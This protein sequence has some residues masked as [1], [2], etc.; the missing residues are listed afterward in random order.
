MRKQFQ[1]FSVTVLFLLQSLAI[2]AA[3]SYQVPDSG[4]EDWSDSFNGNPAPGATWNAANLHKVAVGIHVYGQVCHRVGGADAHSG[5]YAAK[6]V[7]TEVGAA[8][9]T[10]VSP[11]WI[12]LGTPWA[13]IDGIKTGTATAGTDGGI[14]FTH[15]PDTMAVWVK[16]VSEGTENINLVYY[17]WKGTAKGNR[18]KNKDGGCEPTDEHTDEE[19]DIR[20]Q[21][22]PNIC[23]S[24]GNALQIG[25]GALRTNAQYKN[26]TQIKVPI[27]YYNDYTPEKMNIILSA[28]NYP[29]GRRN[30][31][32]YNGNYMIVD[33]LSLIYSSKIHEIRLNNE[34]LNK[35]KQDVYVYSVS[36]GDKATFR[37]IPNITCKR[38]GRTLSG[39]EITINYAEQ[40]GDTTTITV[41]A[42]D[43]SSTSTYKVVFKQTESINSNA[44]A[45][46]VNGKSIPSF[47]GYVT[48]YNV[49]LP[50][51]T[52]DAPEI[53]VTKSEQSQDVEVVSCS[54]FPCVAK[55]IVRAENRSYE[56]VYNINLS[57][58]QLSDNTLQDIKI[59]GNSIPGFKPETNTYLVELPLGTTA[60]PTIEAVSKYKEGDQKITITNAGLNG[61]STIVVTPPVGTSRTYRI[62]YV[63]TESSYSYLK[64]IQVG[65]VSLA[66]FNP[67]TTQYE[68]Q[69]P[70]GTTKLPA[71]TWTLGDPYQTV[72][73]SEDGV[74]GTARITVKA[75][76]GNITIYR[77]A[78]SVEKSTV[79]TLNNIF[80]N[81]IP[82][83]GFA[84]DTYEYVYNVTGAVSTRPV[85]T[86]ETADAYQVVTKNP[87]SEST[88][89]LEGVTKLTVRAQNGNSA[90]YSITFTQKLSDN[91]N[92][93]DLQVAGY[94]LTP[95]FNSDITEYTCKLNRGTSTVPAITFVKGDDT[96][97][98]RVDE[99]GVNGVTK[100]TVKAQTGATK[101]Y[102]ITFSVE[103]SSD[104]TLKDILVGGVSVDG[105]NPATLEYN[106]TLPAGTTVLPTVEAVKND[107]AQRIAMIKGGVN[108]TTE[109][110]VVAEDGTEQTYLLHFSVEKSLNAN[111]QNIYVGGEPLPNFDPDVMMYRYVLA[112]N[113]SSCPIVKAEGYPGQTITTTMPKL[114]GTARIEVQPEI[115]SANV[116][117]IE[118]VREMSDNNRLKNMMV[119]GKDFGFTPE[120]NDYTITMPEGTTQVPTV[121]YSKGED[122][123]TVQIISGGLYG[124]TQVVVVAEDGSKNIYSISFTV[125]QSANVQLKGIYV[126]GTL[127]SD[128]DPNKLTYSYKL[129]NGTTVLPEVT[130]KSQ[131]G[132]HVSLLLPRLEGDA[133]FE[134]TSE[135]GAEKATYVVTFET[136]KLSDATL[137]GIFLDGNTLAGFDAQIFDYTLDI[138]KGAKLPVITYKK[139]DATQQVVVNNQGLNGC[140]LTVK[141]QSGVESTYTIQFNELVSSSAL[142]SDIQFY[143]SA[144]QT[145]TSIDN[146][147][148]NTFEYNIQL[149]WGTKVLPIINPVPSTY[150]QEIQMTEGGVNGV[151]TILVKSADETVSETYKLNF[152][153]E[154]SS[155]ATLD[156]ILV[157][158]NDVPGF[159]PMTFEY[160]VSLPYGTEMVPAIDFEHAKKNG[161]PIVGQKVEI[162][163][164]GLINGVR[165]NVTSEDETDKRT[166]ILRFKV[167]PS[168]KPNVLKS[169][170]AG[171][172]SVPL[173][174]GVFDYNITLPEGVTELPQLTAEKTYSEQEVRVAKVANSY[175]VTVISN[176]DNVDDVVYTITCNYTKPSMVITGV[177]LKNGAKL[178]PAFSPE[179][180]QYMAQASSK[181]DISFLYDDSRY[182]MKFPAAQNTDK[183]ITAVISKIGDASESKTYTFYLYQGEWN[184]NYPN[185][186]L[187]GAQTTG[188][189]EKEFSLIAPVKSIKFKSKESGWTCSVGDLVLYEYVN[190]WNEI[191]R[192]VDINCKEW[193][194]FESGVNPQAQ[195]LKFL[196]TKG[197]TGYAWA[198]NIVVEYAQP[199]IHSLKVNNKAATKNGNNFTVTI[200][201]DAYGIP[202]LDIISDVKNNTYG[203]HWQ[204]VLE[205]ESYDIKWG[206]EVD[207]E[208]KA[209]IVYYNNQ[210]NSFTYTL[211]V[212]R[213][214]STTNT[215]KELVV[216][217]AKNQ[218]AKLTPAFDPE[219]LEYSINIPYTQRELPNISVA[220]TSAYA[221]VS[222]SHINNLSNP[223][224]VS[225]INVTVTSQSGTNR[226]YTVRVLPSPTDESQLIDLSVEGYDID[227]SSGKDHFYVTLPAGTD[228]LP[229]I[230]YTKATDGQKVTINKGKTTTIHVKSEHLTET[231]YYIHF[232]NEEVNTHAQLDLLAVLNVDNMAPQFESGV[233]EYNAIRTDKHPVVI[234]NKVGNEDGLTVT[235]KKDLVK[236]DLN[237]S[238]PRSGVYEEASYVVN[239][240]E[241]VTDNASLETIKINGVGLANFDAQTTDY[242]IPTES[243]DGI[244]IEPVLSEVGQT[245][246]MTFDGTTKTYTIVLTASDKQ[247]VKTYTVKFVQPIS[248]NANL[249]AIWIDNQMISG[250]DANVTEYSYTVRYTDSETPQP[251]WQ[252]PVMPDIKAVGA[253]MG[254]TISIETNG[255]NGKSY[256]NV[257]AENGAEKTY[258]IAFEA[259]KSDYV[260][261]K[262]IFKDSEAITEFYPTLNV[263]E[264]EVP[265]TVQR[266]VIS[267]EPGDAFQVINEVEEADKHIIVVTAQSGDTFTYTINFNKTYAKNALLNGIT[268]DGE[269]L[270]G[271]TSDDYEY[272][273]E[274]PVG[275]TVLPII[276]VIN[277]ADGQTTQVVTN[278]VHG[279]A[280]I[281]VTADDNTTTQTYTIHFTVDK[282]QVNTLLDI[283]LD[284]VSLEG[285]EPNIYEYTHNMPVGSR[286]WPLVSWTAGDAYQT[287]EMSETEIDTWNKVVTLLVK[288]EDET[289]E[290]KTYTVNIIVEKS[291]V[292]TLKDIQL[293]NV[294]LEG[295][296]AET[297][298]YLIELPVGTKQYPLVTYT[299]GDEFQVVNQEVEDNKV[300]I[301]VTAE[302]GA[303]RTY[304]LEFV[305]LH[306]SNAT[307]NSISV[308][309]EILPDFSPEKLAYNYVLPYGTTEMPIVTYE[310]GDKWQNI[311][312]VDGGINGD[313]VINV[314]AEDDVTTLS[315][316]I[317][318]SVALSNNA[319]LSDILVDEQSMPNFDSEVF[320]Y[321]YNLPYNVTEIPTVTAVTIEGQ[322]VNI[323]N[324]TSIDEVTT[325][326]VTAE[327]G[328]TKNVYTIAWENEKSSNALLEMIYLNGVEL[329]GYD[330]EVSDYD[331]TL[332]YGTTQMPEITWLAGDAD[333]TVTLQ[334]NEQTA[335]L[336]VEAQ[337]GTP[338]EYVLTFTVEKSSENR[339][340]DLA[341][342]GVTIEGFD[343]E[344]VEYRIVY[345]A[346]TSKEEVVTVSQV[347]YQLFNDSETVTLLNNDMVLMIQVMA[348]NGD[349]RTYVIVQEIALSNNTL[350]DDILID[351]ES[352]ENFDPNTFEYTY[353]LPFGSAIVPD[354][355]RYVSSDTTQNVSVSVNPLPMPSEIFV[356]AEDGSKAVYRIHF[357]VDDFDPATV[358]TAD[359]VC[360]TSMPNGK[361]KF[362]TNCNNVTIYLSTIDGKV[363]LVAPLPLVD[364]NVPNIC[365]EQAQGFIFEERV[366]NIVAYYFIHNKQYIIQSGK[367]R[368]SHQ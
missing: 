294:S 223:E 129:N 274:L 367:L 213:P 50:Y 263:Y 345:P 100:I 27:T 91:V 284:G 202:T 203:A 250:F 36:L 73:V 166:Y 338:G 125:Q 241:K 142:L 155:V 272:D 150:G 212:K 173:K 227:F 238:L 23:G 314:K 182:E 242:E 353:Y 268:L 224:A 168:G 84:P 31:G 139:Q 279:D 55:V 354:D 114:V 211:T 74:D 46:S 1:V 298:E 75:Q 72:S 358:P 89:S 128:F 159:D 78:F 88:V 7:D 149:P 299:K 350:L 247:T 178:Y 273:V 132:Q 356:T 65:G 130:Y 183:K 254:Q 226:M 30:D 315:Y 309:Y 194:E 160:T 261:L 15:R 126:G 92:L 90:V 39:D 349:M 196:I 111:L 40:L 365:D 186:E 360:V 207:G 115:G 282:S 156:N 293:D 9:I 80:V 120:Q 85:V 300:Y 256:I 366:D 340:K 66:D 12:T 361:W 103:T 62:S 177:E 341:I 18:Y 164:A 326:T 81:G 197:V 190:G 127:L 318:F 148:E 118:F 222:F 102:S 135:D 257:K 136:E 137:K 336:L 110:K 248:D 346:G 22:D 161:N 59:N 63:I 42:E 205:G 143:N 69:L 101:V 48:D 323:V 193:V 287:V 5:N 179:V 295:Y 233:Y 252:E 329:E 312:V 343:P 171:Q 184:K 43:G 58:G 93:T 208:R 131:E 187:W 228:V 25:E 17:S 6:L 144:T 119:N 219:R 347:T 51:G 334:W 104:A 342:N 145:F 152:S 121:T 169:M 285:F 3:S 199:G 236:L 215:L 291:D 188:S 99:N 45:I 339:L 271:F 265:V 237:C 185:I 13:Y 234:Y 322:S 327:D 288:P 70:L 368:V 245:M 297:T 330:P 21:T 359:N 56:T 319:L 289:I 16:R 249:S 2:I 276:G 201:Q 60:D 123:Q 122:K 310:A 116:Y 305:I 337:D 34:P 86:W 192:D 170:V 20:I 262:N 141:A 280:V 71:I 162:I 180:T 87:A 108:G 259:Q 308:D 362:T 290:S 49:E 163:D 172:T 106:V 251:K 8:G 332:P 240:S 28:S 19:S 140:T 29:E 98:V 320:N 302:N 138:T 37:D 278:G 296:D 325:I 335:L 112:E 35:F 158:G 95:A 260:Y 232:V 306:S 52:T 105:F 54:D 348:E 333:Q 97:V 321:T 301:S 246:V 253:D 316:I 64:D 344:V 146:F 189:E 264:F 79:T 270:A 255:I 94:N 244:E 33:D 267:Y 198:E 53:T 209:T 117:T 324:A 331:I 77:I 317:H 176:Q 4:F 26:W 311:S 44:A 151:T 286:V 275:T 157:N 243:L 229:A 221:S 181:Q 313:Y 231:T 235:Y 191:V 67:E 154:K 38:S 200:D 216:E 124:T 57:I 32:L 96:Q 220:P 266:P 277:G 225:S 307:L 153:V 292:N 363:I 11:A 10:E 230:S 41:R 204:S 218:G 82:L 134:V 281:T 352:L 113:M 83:N 47:S 258:E 328:V 217:G 107:A 68:M 133:K 14:T 109:I 206:E 355:I 24:G 357:I 351:G 175:V 239:L 283:Q 147:N 165:I 76:N 303:Q 364:V 214:V 269:L 210:L 195:K 167:A 61:R 174:D 304:A